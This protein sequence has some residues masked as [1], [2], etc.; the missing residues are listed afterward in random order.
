MQFTKKNFIL[1][2]DQLRDVFFWSLSSKHS[3]YIYLIM[4]A[5]GL[6]MLLSCGY[7]LNL[8]S[9][10]VAWISVIFIYNLLKVE[11]QSSPP[12]CRLSSFTFPAD[13][14]GF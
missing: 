7:G 13:L 8:F 10:V 14:I 6:R 2:P 1:A 4:V 5:I 12:N 3:N 9:V 11:G